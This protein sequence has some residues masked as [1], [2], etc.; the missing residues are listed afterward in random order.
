MDEFR[1]VVAEMEHEEHDLW[2]KRAQ[3]VE[4]F[5][6]DGAFDDLAGHVDLPLA[7]DDRLPSSSRARWP[8][9]LI[10]VVQHAEL[11]GGAADRGQSAGV[12]AKEQ[13][14]AMSQITTTISELW[15]TPRQIAEKA[16]GRADRR[17]GGIWRRGR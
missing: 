12:G 7:G 2:A 13:A 3:D 16:T 14:T 11:L 4:A 15:A 5:L 10:R 1:A 8:R 6:V 9:R 17:G